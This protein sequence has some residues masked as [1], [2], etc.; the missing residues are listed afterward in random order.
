MHTSKIHFI[1]WQGAE[2]IPANLLNN[3]REWRRLN[4]DRD[5][6]TWCEKTI[7]SD[8]KI[9]ETFPWLNAELDNIIGTT[10]GSVLIKKCDL[11]RLAICYCYGG[12]YLDCDLVPVGG[13]SV[14]QLTDF[15]GSGKV[16]NKF[17]TD[18]TVMPEQPSIDFISL[19]ECEVILSRE[20]C[21][22]DSIG[23]GVANG[24]IICQQESKVL[25]EFINSR[26]GQYHELALNYMGTW[27]LTKFIREKVASIRGL[28]TILPHHYFL[29]PVGFMKCNEQS[30]T[31]SIHPAQNS[32]GDHTKKEWWKV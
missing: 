5:V 6:Y 9:Q 29:W 16:F 32:W 27:A 2:E 13:S 8:P 3:I 20:F 30:Y 15:I 19:T 7:R 4:S 22:I 28:V 10:E 1:W 21:K 17:I 11:A 31:I 18:S 12:V 25:L 24:V 14:S 23:R 26:K